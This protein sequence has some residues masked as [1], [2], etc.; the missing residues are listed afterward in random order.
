MDNAAGRMPAQSAAGVFLRQAPNLLFMCALTATVEYNTV[1][2]SYMNRKNRKSTIS[3][4][5]QGDHGNEA[6]LGARV[7]HTVDLRQD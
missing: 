5:V 1:T 3:L 6:M 7:G 2:Q 4:L